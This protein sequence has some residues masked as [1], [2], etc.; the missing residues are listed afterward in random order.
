M[1]WLSNDQIVYPWIIGLIVLMLSYY[2]I[3]ILIKYC[4]IILGK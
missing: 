2:P 1:V 3:K 4:P